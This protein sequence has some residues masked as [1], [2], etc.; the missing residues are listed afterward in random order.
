MYQHGK[1]GE[2]LLFVINLDNRLFMLIRSLTSLIQKILIYVDYDYYNRL[3]IRQKIRK[4]TIF[5]LLKLSRLH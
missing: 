1:V 5:H 4:T 2:S 3:A